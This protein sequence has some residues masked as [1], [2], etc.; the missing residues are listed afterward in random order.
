MRRLPNRGLI[1][2]GSAARQPIFFSFIMSMSADDRAMIL[3][4]SYGAEPCDAGR[5]Y[6]RSYDTKSS[7]TYVS[8]T[9]GPRSA[10]FC[11]HMRVDELH[12]PAKFNKNPQRP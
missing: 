1:T 6:E 3:H 9:A 4:R 5:K 7:I 10:N 12:S 11:V 2:V 8:Q